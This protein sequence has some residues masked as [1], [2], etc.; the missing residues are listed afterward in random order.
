[1]TEDEQLNNRVIEHL[2]TLYSWKNGT[3]EWKLDTLQQEITSK[4]LSL[5]T[6]KIC[7]LSSRQIGKS[8]WACVFILIYLI[9]NP[10]K[11]A[12][13]VAPTLKQC[14]DIVNDNLS[15]ILEDCPKGI[16]KRKRSAYR[17]DLSNGSS[18]RL[19]SM[20]RANSDSNRGGNASLILYE[21]CGFV[22]AEAFN[23]CINS[24]LAPQLLRSKGVQIFVSTPSE[25]TE[26]P[27]HT[28]IAE[29]C[30]LLGSFFKFTVFD[31]PSIEKE[32][33]DEAV[34]RCGG[35][36]TESFRREYMAEIVRSSTLS[37]IPS[38]DES[39]HVRLMP[40]D[41]TFR[42]VISIDWGGVRDFT[43]LIVHTYVQ[44]QDLDII[45]DELYFEPNTSTKIIADAIKE[46]ISK[47]KN[48]VIDNIIADVPG[49]I[50]VDLRESYGLDISAPN[51]VDW[52]SNVQHVASRFHL[53]KVVIN[54]SCRFLIKS[55]KGALFNNQRTDFARIQGLGHCDAIAALMYGM[56]HTDKSKVH[57]D[58][59]FMYGTSMVNKGDV[60]QEAKLLMNKHAIKH[61]V[62]QFGKY[63]V[64]K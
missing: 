24:V 45:L 17:W 10:G 29:Q 28:V 47:Y 31:S 57:N 34:D 15:K 61:E 8:Y 64:K 56:K 5:N 46:I 2:L 4:L 41:V 3:L 33:I 63:K 35:I 62:R 48:N 52:L 23:Y 58:Q 32:M 22:N 21:E 36:N 18:L 11:I 13:I 26:H 16:I 54:P 43:A 59:Y 40:V 37:V 14:N 60:R 7:I 25:D 27:L 19:G 12:R 53:N 30:K 42:L 20:D 50:Q 9:K 49:Q 44:R 39:K 51:K 1:V 55:C 6:K 38:F